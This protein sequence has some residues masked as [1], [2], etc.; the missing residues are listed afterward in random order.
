MG[1]RLT[2]IMEVIADAFSPLFNYCHSSCKLV[3]RGFVNDITGLV[4]DNE[5]LVTLHR[6]AT[7]M[8]L[9]TA[10]LSQTEEYNRCFFFLFFFPDQ[11]PLSLVSVLLFSILSNRWDTFGSAQKSYLLLL[12]SLGFA[13]AVLHGLVHCFGQKLKH[14]NRFWMDCHETTVQHRSS[15]VLESSTQN[16]SICPVCTFQNWT[17][18]QMITH[19]LKCSIYFFNVW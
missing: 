3:D 6:L 10:A 2:L 5:P 1:D 18:Q 11:P 14:L 4:P 19:K 13:L 12:S 15:C 7:Q 17:Y 9:T 8:I 16:L